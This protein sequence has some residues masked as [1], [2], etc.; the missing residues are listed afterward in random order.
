M[1]LAT[2][3]KQ[4]VPPSIVITLYVKMVRGKRKSARTL[5][6][7][8]RE[9]YKRAKLSASGPEKA[10]SAS[11]HH[12]G[13]CLV[14]G[15]FHQG[16]ASLRPAAGRQC[17]CTSLAFMLRAK[18]QPQFQVW[19][20][21]HLDSIVRHGTVIYNNIPDKTGAFLLIS[22]LPAAVTIHNYKFLLTM[23]QPFGGTINRQETDGPFYTIHDAL[24]ESFRVA[25][26]AFLTLESYMCGIVCSSLHNQAFFMFDSHSRD[27]AGY[28]CEN[29]ASI[30]MRFESLHDISQHIGHLAQSMG[31]GIEVF[32]ITPVCVRVEQ[33][34]P[35]TATHCVEPATTGDDSYSFWP[36]LGGEHATEQFRAGTDF[37]AELTCLIDP[38]KAT[39]FDG[40]GC[41]FCSDTFSGDNTVNNSEALPI[42][43]SNDQSAE[44]LPSQCE[45][46]YERKKAR[47][48]ARYKSSNRFR[49]KKQQSSRDKYCTNPQFAE[50]HKA[51]MRDYMLKRFQTDAK[52]AAAHK[53]FMREYMHDRFVTDAEFA[54]Y[55]REYM[56]NLYQTD[57]DYAE[58]HKEYMHNLY[59]T[60]PDFAEHHKEHMHEYMHERATDA[61][62]REE[63]NRNRKEN[64]HHSES[65]REKQQAAL[66]RCR[67]KA[68]EKR[69][70]LDEVIRDFKVKAKEGPSCI[71]CS[72]YRLFFKE[73]VKECDPNKY[74][75][76]RNVVD[77]C[78]RTDLRHLCTVDCDA[79][80]PKG[81]LWVCST[82]KGYLQ[83]G[84][85]P[86]LSVANGLATEPQP[87]ELAT[88]NKLEQQLI[89]LRL[90]FM[91]IL[92]NLPS[93]KQKGV[94]GPVVMVPANVSRTATALPRMLGE[95]QLVTV[96]L[97][98]KLTFT[99]YVEC[100]TINTNKVND[101]LAYL[102]Q[103]S[104][105]YKDITLYEGW[106]ETDEDGLQQLQAENIDVPDDSANTDGSHQNVDGAVTTDSKVQYEAT[107]PDDSRN[108]AQAEPHYRANQIVEPNGTPS[109]EPMLNTNDRE[110]EVS[111]QDEG[112]GIVNDSCVQPLD[113]HTMALAE[114]QDAI[115]SVAPGE[116]N[117]PVSI[118]LAD[119]AEAQTYVMIG[120]LNHQCTYTRSDC[121]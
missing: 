16:H 85:M 14:R 118:F 59:Q 60:N 44:S 4:T 55:Q 2:A 121:K 94:H 103:H 9:C 10:L 78:I 75:K 83:K 39:H 43:T 36:D 87:Y 29:G 3:V 100:D 71:C 82:C 119:N 42:S 66:R 26:Q 23:S 99:G 31:Q 63:I 51:R 57:P 41:S 84:Q 19:T 52:F 117:Q 13:S 46:A 113:M 101:A 89:A 7:E 79:K 120:W 90:P 6:A 8:R 80:C 15:S 35:E 61:S 112:Q 97:K 28:Q 49:E 86:P 30:C 22:D 65:V 47:Q 12:L 95:S 104:L 73:Q 40:A 74:T 33:S 98:R 111:Q 48:R 70:D 53:E 34:V 17:T 54:D 105:L 11:E 93:G 1:I 67:D 68:K 81:K 24:A 25:S 102:K 116:G 69:S 92:A 38:P 37:E 64:Y 88:L 58:Y 76:N 45:S 91:T 20:S 56:Q 50:N 21:Q 72:C 107:E 106:H 5:K 108:T 77:E 110:T 62:F 27:S 114:M 96:K 32:E 115:I 109:D 18:V